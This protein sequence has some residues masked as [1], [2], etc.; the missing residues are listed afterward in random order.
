MYE[1]EEEEEEEKEEEEGRGRAAVKLYWPTSQV[2]QYY[3]IYSQ[4]ISRSEF[5]LGRASHRCIGSELYH[6][7]ANAATA[8]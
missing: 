4:S 8:R 2:R 5:Y 3:N 7:P 1:E 6:A